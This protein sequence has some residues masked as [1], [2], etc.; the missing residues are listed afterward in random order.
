[1][2]TLV[3]ILVQTSRQHEYDHV[4]STPEVSHLTHSGN[5]VCSG[6]P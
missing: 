1:M 3:E 6:N 5:E 4:S 2:Q